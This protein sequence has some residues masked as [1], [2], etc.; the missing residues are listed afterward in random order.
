MRDAQLDRVRHDAR[1][2]VADALHDGLVQSMT[3]L[4][5]R[6]ALASLHAQPEVARAL[7]EVELELASVVAELRELVAGLLSTSLTEVDQS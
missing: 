1:R 3:A 6:V 4:M 2:E 5:M 7:D